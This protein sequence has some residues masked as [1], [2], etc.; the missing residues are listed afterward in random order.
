MSLINGPN[1]I[2]NNHI[3]MIKQM[4]NWQIFRFLKFSG[5]AEFFKKNLLVGLQV[6]NQNS[7]IDHF[8]RNTISYL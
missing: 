2:N 6:L 7:S 8:A 4:L 1:L 3:I 5:V